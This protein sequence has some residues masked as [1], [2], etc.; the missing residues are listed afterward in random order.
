MATVVID[1]SLRHEFDGRWRRFTDQK[2]KETKAD[3]GLA[4]IVDPVI[5]G[6]NPD[7]RITYLRVNSQF[8]ESLQKD[9]FGEVWD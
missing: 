7:G 5:Q 3:W 2:A 8:A 6:P 1:A 9:K 4:I